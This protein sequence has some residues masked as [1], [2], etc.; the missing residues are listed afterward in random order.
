KDCDRVHSVLAALGLGAATTNPEGEGGCRPD[1]GEQVRAAAPECRV[2]LL[3]RYHDL[4]GYARVAKVAPCLWQAGLDVMVVP[5]PGLPAHGDVSDW[6]HQGKDALDL[7]PYAHESGIPWTPALAEQCDSVAWPFLAPRAQAA[8]EPEPAPAPDPGP[9]W[10]SQWEDPV[11]MLQR[12][13]PPRV[14]LIAGLLPSSGFTLW[15]GRAKS[16]KS[17]VCLYASLALALGLDTVAGLKVN[18][19]KRV[20]FIEEE[21]PEDRTQDRIRGMLSALT[22]HHWNDMDTQDPLRSHFRY[23]CLGGYRMDTETWGDLERELDHWPPD[24]FVF[25]AARKLTRHSDV[26]DPKVLHGRVD[27]LQAMSIAR[28]LSFHLIA[29][30]RKG[31]AG[32]VRRGGGDPFALDN[33]AGGLD[34]QAEADVV[35]RLVRF[36]LTDVRLLVRSKDEEAIG[37]YSV[38]V[39]KDTDNMTVDLAL[40]EEQAE[41]SRAKGAGN[42]A[43]VYMAFM[44]CPETKGS[45]GGSG[46]SAVDL[47]VY[48]GLSVRTVHRHLED[49]VDAKRIVESGRTHSTEPGKDGKRG[50][51]SKLYRVTQGPEDYGQVFDFPSVP[52]PREPGSDDT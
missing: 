50:K 7:V 9:V 41:Q 8:P 4:A 3:P 27:Q 34:L 5:F 16:Y 43:A 20:V 31:P 11:V 47:A 26:I 23:R 49:L 33:I 24:I 22:G 17:T 1:Y 28:R 30:D 46:V 25:D 19:R 18:T 12:E 35:L 14:P 10:V 44:H 38:K 51:P 2:V 42:R 40:V 29:H 36:S 13:H 52:N 21:D 37:P 15:S 6:L 48:T 39:R 32:D 45:F